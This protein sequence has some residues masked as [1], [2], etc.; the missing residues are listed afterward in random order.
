MKSVLHHIHAGLL[1]PPPSIAAWSSSRRTGQTG[2]RS[3]PTAR[4]G[5]QAVGW[6]KAALLRGFSGV[7]VW[8]L[9]SFGGGCEFVA[10]LPG[11]FHLAWRNHPTLVRALGL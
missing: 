5:D 10:A 3:V 2:V 6:K 8:L 11:H 9:R 7:G 4:C 1:V